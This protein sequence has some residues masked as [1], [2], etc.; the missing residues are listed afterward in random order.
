MEERLLKKI[1]CVLLSLILIL[2]VFFSMSVP[3]S[4]SFNSLLETEADVV[5]LVNTDTGNVIFD[6]NASK[7]T[8]PASLTKI[9]TCMLVLENCE[10]LNTTVTAKRSCIE[11]LYGMNAATVGILAGEQLTVD[12]LLHC[13]MIPSA[14]DAANVLADFIGGSI[15]NFVVMMNDFVKKLGCENTNFTNPSGLDNG[16]TNMYTTAEDLY[17]ITS[18]AL[19]N[20]QFKELCN[21]LRYQIEPTEKYPQI[22][23][24]NNTNKMLNP[25]IKDYYSPYVAGVKTGTTG[26]AGHCVIT[27][28]SKNG[29]NYMLIVMNA[30]QYDIDNDGVEENVAFTDSKKIYEWAFKNIVLTKVTSKTDIVTVVDVKYNWKTD[31]LSL[32]PEEE[33]SALVPTGT[34]S[35][36]LQI[37]A[38][39]SE[40][41]KTVNAPIKKGDVLGKAEVLYGDDVV[42][43]VNL[44]ASE[45]VSGSV[46]LR[47]AG[48][49]GAIFRTPIMKI[50][51]CLAVLLLVIYIFL[52]VRR[53]RIRAKRRKPR[54]IK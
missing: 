51:I 37:R 44:V 32:V 54:R 40:T 36:S 1:F 5:M 19:K 34:Q 12:E 20:P 49:L 7:R 16:D 24:L 15:D 42:A 46:I 30:P 18:Y 38:I 10:D 33:I 28:A 23:Y 8:A 43:T 17:K 27:T 31:H 13:L 4:A 9:V 35:G 45:D 21:I 3:S 26:L 48:F 22:R 11:A 6:K 2:T 25:A 50:L 53:N 29:Y 41:P 14:A 47:I 39:E 52:I